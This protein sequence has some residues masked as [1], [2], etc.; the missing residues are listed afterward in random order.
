MI[1][2]ILKKIIKRLLS[3]FCMLK[4]KKYIV[5]MF[6]IIIQ[7]VKIR[8]FF[9]DY[10]RR[11]LQQKKLSALLMI[12]TSNIRVIFIE[13]SVLKQKLSFNHIKILEFNQHQ[14]SDKSTISHLCR[15]R[16]FNKK[17][18]DVKRILK[19]HLQQK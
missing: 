9:N 11:R 5:P 14:K 19:I 17:M 18:M 7:I 8:F 16:M 1:E 3:I 12:A 15:S 6:Q 10:K 13:W 4:K 2:K